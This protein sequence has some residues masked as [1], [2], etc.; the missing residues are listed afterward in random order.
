MLLKALFLDGLMSWIGDFVTPK[1][2][3][4][5]GSSLIAEDNLW[6]MCPT[7][8]KL[9][10]HKE[11]EENLMVCG[12]CSHHFMLDWERRLESLFDDK[13]YENISSV[14]V[15]NDPLKFKDTKKYVDRLKEARQ[16]T[17]L[18]E[19]IVMAR[20]K[21][22]EISVIVF[23]MDFKFIGG[24]M[25]LAVGKS[26]VKAVNTAISTKSALIGFTA[27]GGA[28][29][30]EGILS[31][32]QMPATVASLCNLKEFG[33]PYINVF[34]HPTTGGVLASFA[35]LGDIHI[36]EPNAVIGFAGTR[37]IEKIMKRKLPEG[38]QKAEF[39]QDHGMIDMIVPRSQLRSKLATILDYTMRQN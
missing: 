7:C 23:V 13:K 19:A 18:T 4:F 6:T 38:F 33:L 21:I 11:I 17:G 5:M 10:Y 35:M 1:I 32:M 37:V 28:R 26:F 24:S 27:S 25:G 20:G 9:L 31:L 2:K 16:K 22:N 30:Q 36:A 29:M 14:R 15:K 12:Y 34:T 3:A 39:L 8:E